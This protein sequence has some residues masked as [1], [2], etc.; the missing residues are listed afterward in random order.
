MS[1]LLHSLIFIFLVSFVHVALELDPDDW[2]T[3]YY[4]GE[5]QGVLGDREAARKTFHE[6]AALEMS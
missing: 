4:Y 3:L 5:M 1:R 6:A 2:L